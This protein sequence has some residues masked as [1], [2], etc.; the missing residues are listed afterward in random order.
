MRYL[1][2]CSVL[3]ASLLAPASAQTIA[4][5][6]GLTALAERLG[7]VVPTGAGVVV[8][9]VEAQ[10]GMAYA[11]DA[12]HA[13]FAGKTITSASPGS[14][15]SGHATTVGRHFYGLDTGIA[16]GSVDIRSYSVTHWAGAGFLGGSALG[17]EPLQAGEVR[18]FNHSW[19]GSLSGANNY[20]RK[21]DQIIAEQEVVMTYGVNNGSQALDA[22]MLGQAFNGLAVGRS[23]G[24]HAH[25]V[26]SP[27]LDGPGR[28]KP[29]LVAPGSA[30]SWATP[31]VGGAVALL[32]ETA[33]TDAGLLANPNAAR[34]MLLKAVLMA[35][36]EKRAGW[37]NGASTEACSAGRR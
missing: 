27:F 34:A 18:I 35:G 13:E 2:C 20:L 1:S 4:D 17:S 16:P 31:L 32:I 30:T 28:M 22:T 3:F 26:T 21:V 24:L 5:D 7:G 9:Q 15:V 37:S 36:A 8:A 29:E 33:E 6:T 19:V 12:G 11:P 25:G 14:G 23:D 10:V